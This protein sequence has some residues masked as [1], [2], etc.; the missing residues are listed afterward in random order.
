[1]CFLPDGQEI[2]LLIRLFLTE[3][4]YSIITLDDCERSALF[5]TVV[6]SFYIFVYV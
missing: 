5:W 4:K 3:L 2:I 6:Y 1:M